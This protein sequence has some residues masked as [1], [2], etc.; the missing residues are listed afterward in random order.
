MPNTG[1]LTEA[2]IAQVVP[3]DSLPIV[4]FLIHSSSPSSSGFEQV[5]RVRPWRPSRARPT[6]SSPL[7]LSLAYLQYQDQQAMVLE[8]LGS[9]SVEPVSTP[10]S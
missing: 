2:N 5:L 6:T 8:L 10:C 3:L 4:T 1:A 7:D 9:R